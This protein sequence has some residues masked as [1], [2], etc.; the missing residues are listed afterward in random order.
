[1][2]LILEHLLPLLIGGVAANAFNPINASTLASESARKYPL[3]L[4]PIV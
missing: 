2:A 3:L 4:M 1:M